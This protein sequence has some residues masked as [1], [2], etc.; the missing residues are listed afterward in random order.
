M[1]MSMIKVADCK[2]SATNVKGRNEGKSFDDLVASIKEKGILMPIL[3][4]L[5]GEVEMTKKGIKSDHYE[6]VAGNRR[7]AAA[8]KLGL[9]EIPA[10]IVVMT[11]IEARE[12][13]I[14]ENLQRQDIHPLDE[15]E[16]Y[17]Q[18]IEK[19]TPRY[20]VK[21]VAL[22]VGKSET[23][24]KQRLAMTNLSVKAAKALREGEINISHALVISRLDSD[25]QQ[26]DATN[27]AKDSSVEDL[28]EWIEK[29]VYNDLAGKP[30][31]KNAKLAEMVGD[32]SAKPENLFG[33]K[34]LGA[35]PAVVAR[36]MAA[37]IEIKLREAQS[38][39]EKLVRIST[40]WGTPDLKGV[41]GKD[42]YR[43]VTAKDKDVKEVIKG[44]VVEGDD[45]GRIFKI[46]TEKEQI[47]GSSVYKPT[48][49]EKAKRKKENEAKKKKEENNIAK[50]QEAIGKIKFPLSEKQLDIL[51]DFTLVRCGYS[52]QQ[53]VAKLI[54]AELV[55]KKETVPSYDSEK[56][57]KVRIST[58]HE[59]TIRKYA[60]DNGAVGKL[61]AVFA[62]LMP[63]PSTN[64]YDDGKSFN[65]AVKKF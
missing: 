1:K 38:K 50:F 30:W 3:V 37:F 7:L 9:D 27:E 51:L 40:S 25:K 60:K 12:A 52:F 5:A 26:D 54:G 19:S 20:E 16:Q 44:I 35:D 18:L 41:L 47:K 46:T 57:G 22:K 28:K 23:Y 63:H 17:R 42:E 4:R 34:A 45:R 61:R 58:D 13:Q 55:Q 14:V 31:V 36:Q 39:G 65:D 56:K 53:P 49:A 59:A 48:A 29:R 15:G 6:V 2:Q 33:D 43:I 11:N 64:E 24:V 32:M 21:D 10:K 8:K 62:L